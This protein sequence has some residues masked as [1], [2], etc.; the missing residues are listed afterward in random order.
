MTAIIDNV[1]VSASSGTDTVNRVERIVLS[2]LITEMAAVSGNLKTASRRLGVRAV[3]LNLGA[4]LSLPHIW[5]I[6][7]LCTK[8]IDSEYE[9]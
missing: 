1:I 3:A 2:H 4:E 6:F 8:D 9:M 7:N 5:C